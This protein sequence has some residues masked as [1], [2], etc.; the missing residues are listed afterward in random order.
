MDMRMSVLNTV[1]GTLNDQLKEKTGQQVYPGS[2]G[3]IAESLRQQVKAGYAEQKRPG[4][5][6]Q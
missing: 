1:R 2:L 6:Q 5:C 3:K 4:K